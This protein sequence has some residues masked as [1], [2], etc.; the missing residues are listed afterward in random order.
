MLTILRNIGLLTLSTV[1]TTL[2]GLVATGWLARALQPEQFGV[3]GFGTAL[4]GFFSLLVNSG[5]ATLAM[6][7]IARDPGCVPELTGTVVSLRLT[8]SL[9]SYGAFAAVLFALDLPADARAV[10]LVQGVQLIAQAL[11]LDFVF[12]GIQRMGAIALR[13]IGTA[14]LTLGATVLL[15]HDSGDTAIAAGITAGSAA[16]NALWI[17]IGYVALFRRMTF[18]FSVRRWWDLLAQSAPISI[19]GFVWMAYHSTGV[20]VLGLMRP[21]AEVGLYSAAYKVVTLV[22]MLAHVIR[23][24]FLP[25]LANVYGD[26]PAMQAGVRRFVVTMA[27]IAVP[28]TVGGMALAPEIL[29]VLF[30]PAFEGARE[31]MRIM[32]AGVP[33]LFLVIVLGD[34]LL[35]WHRQRP[36]MMVMLVCG[37]ANAALCFALTPFL[38]ALG[39]ATAS[40]TTA[41]LMLVGIA[42][43]HIRTVGL[44]PARPLRQAGLSVLLTFA[45]YA[46][47]ALGA[48][49]FTG[50]LVPVAAFLV[51]GCVIVALCGL[52]MMVTGLLPVVRMAGAWRRSAGQQARA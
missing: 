20:L 37:I 25:P 13:Q 45:A 17:W 34:P 52:A 22:V 18:R 5:I 29:A 16:V 10:Y 48:A 19:G 47:F 21:A 1:V 24:A 31:P 23:N 15:V 14:L 9:V 8:L 50:H 30:G 2:C 43:N 28:V 39:A 49:D 33:L 51:K 26:R 36:Y 12:A 27:A 44:L 38:G 3:I 4:V 6:R 32:M 35:V 7:E 42:G 41:A 46:L 11:V 40:V